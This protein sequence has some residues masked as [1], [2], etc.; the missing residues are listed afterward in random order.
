MRCSAGVFAT[1]RQLDGA[2]MIYSVPRI[3]AAVV[4]A[5]VLAA[6]GGLLWL[7]SHVTPPVQAVVHKNL[8]PDRFAVAPPVSVPLAVPTP[9]AAPVA[10]VPAAPVP[11]TTNPGQPAPATHR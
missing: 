11:N 9:A 2:Q 6:G 5:V 1:A 8:P 4:L 7:G 10:S 3:L